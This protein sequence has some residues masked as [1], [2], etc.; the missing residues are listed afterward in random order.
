MLRL[1]YGNRNELEP[2]TTETAA[3]GAPEGG[4][5]IDVAI[6]YRCRAEPWIDLYKLNI[7]SLLREKSF[8]SCEHKR[9]DRITVA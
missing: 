4:C 5:S 3:Q 1:A 6:Q 2:E 9:R 8:V 7:D